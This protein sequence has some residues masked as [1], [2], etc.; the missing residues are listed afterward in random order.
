M[1]EIKRIG[2]IVARADQGADR[3]DEPDLGLLDTVDVD[4]TRVSPL[5]RGVS[6]TSTRQQLFPRLVCAPSNETNLP[7]GGCPAA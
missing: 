7:R 6:S 4:T 1:L 2:R 5:V 3:Q